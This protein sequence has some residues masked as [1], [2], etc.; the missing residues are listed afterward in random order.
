MKKTFTLIELL[1]VIA[2]IAILA[3][4]LLPALS[5]SRM[6]GRSIQCLS[7]LKQM[8]LGLGF[9]ANDNNGWQFGGNRTE[10]VH[11]FLQHCGKQGYLDKYKERG[12]GDASTQGTGIMFC[13]EKKHTQQL[14]MV[15]SDFGVNS[16]LGSVGKY[17]PWHR[18][19]PYGETFASGQGRYYFKPDSIKW[20]T[21][22]PFWI[23]GKSG[24]P[25]IAPAWGWK[26]IEA[27]HDQRASSSFIDGHVE[28][29]Q[30]DVLTRRIN[31]YGFYPN[32]TVTES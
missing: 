31:G 30:E 29:M 4:M 23:D 26:N 6:K 13:P 5:K 17:A 9:Y 1:V 21:K 8:S 25:F 14:N 2:I 32:S 3:G 18:N 12:I 11:E 16:F 15:D 19:L 22:V 27:R 7:N 24:S 20:T 10:I 28:S